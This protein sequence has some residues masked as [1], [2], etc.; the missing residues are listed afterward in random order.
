MSGDEIWSDFFAGVIFVMI[1]RHSTLGSVPPFINTLALPE[2][3]RH[4]AFEHIAYLGGLWSAVRDFS[5]ALGLFDFCLNTPS[6][7]RDWQIIAAMHG[8][9]SI[10]NV[11]LT[12]QNFRAGIGS[13]PTLCSWV[14]HDKLRRAQREFKSAFPGYESMRHALAHSPDLDKTPER[15][16][17]N[18]YIGPFRSDGM[19]IEGSKTRIMVKKSLLGRIFQTTFDGRLLQYEISQNTLD[20]LVEVKDQFHSALARAI[21]EGEKVPNWLP[22]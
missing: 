18:A 7:K 17:Q 9:W 3:E 12:M 8:A 4:L 6:A 19:I 13:T 14:D 1:F 15:R 22:K 2:E 21:Q 20:Q 5:C 10:Y 16:E 11:G